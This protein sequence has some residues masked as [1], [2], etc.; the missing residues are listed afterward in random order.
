MPENVKKKKRINCVT[1]I[2][3]SFANFLYEIEFS[4]SEYELKHEKLTREH[5]N[6][7]LGPCFGEC[8]TFNEVKRKDLSKGSIE[9]FRGKYFVFRL[10]SFYLRSLLARN[11]VLSSKMIQM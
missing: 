6:F 3:N 9:T 8:K 11:R 4:S 2:R 1:T 7:R 10:P 5:N